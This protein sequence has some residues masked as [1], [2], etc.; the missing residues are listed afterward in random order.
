MLLCVSDMLD[1]KKPKKNLW[2]TINLSRYR[3]SG[4]FS[5]RIVL[6][7]SAPSDLN[8]HSQLLRSALPKAPLEPEKYKQG[9]ITS[10]LRAGFTP[11]LL[12]HVWNHLNC[13]SPVS[14]SEYPHLT[15]ICL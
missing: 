3:D 2:T 13:P 10:G 5:G 11:A 6:N 1:I 4:E 9:K 14:R 12:L 7:Y 15:N 8:K